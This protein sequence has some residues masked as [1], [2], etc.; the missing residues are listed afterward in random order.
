MEGENARLRA[1]LA[2]RTSQLHSAVT[3]IGALKSRMDDL[4]LQNDE[5][6]QKQE[7]NRQRAIQELIRQSKEANQNVNVCQSDDDD[8]D[9]PPTS[10]SLKKSTKKAKKN[11]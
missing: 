9:D 10:Y 8:G 5:L 2:H 4:I 6:L 3:R 7:Q 11:K 1:D